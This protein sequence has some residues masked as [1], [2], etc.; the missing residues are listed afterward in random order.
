MFIGI[1][2]GPYKEWIKGICVDR[3]REN[4]TS[5]ETPPLFSVNGIKKSYSICA[6]FRCGYTEYI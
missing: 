4:S 3:G 6:T 2:V 1:S 5:A